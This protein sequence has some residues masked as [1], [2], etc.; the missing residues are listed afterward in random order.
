MTFMSSWSEFFGPLIYLNS[1]DKYTLALAIQQWRQM[2]GMVVFR[3]A[4][5]NHIM[6]MSTLL[7]IPPVLVFF[8]AQRYFVQGVV[9]SGVKG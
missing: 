5:W 1:M 4:K 9:V 3:P 7:T 6:A 8:F 2:A